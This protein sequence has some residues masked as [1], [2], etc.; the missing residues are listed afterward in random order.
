MIDEKTVTKEQ[1]HVNNSTATCCTMIT[2]NQ[3]ST[4]NNWWL[5]RVPTLV[6][7]PC[8]RQSDGTINPDHTRTTWGQ[9]NSQLDWK[10]QEALGR[11]SW[12]RD[13]DRC[14]EGCNSR[15][16]RNFFDNLHH[17]SSIPSL[18]HHEKF[19]ITH[20]SVFNGITLKLS[21][22]VDLEFLNRTWSRK[23]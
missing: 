8:L 6:I 10:G 15:P 19:H 22:K 4:D 3:Q 2:D 5:I 21:R 11:W 20:C 17:C 12:H 23:I 1:A 16:V 18:F 14:V 9:C 13:S 7:G